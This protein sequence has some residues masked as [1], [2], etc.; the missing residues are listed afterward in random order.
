MVVYFLWLA[1]LGWKEL[2]IGKT[3]FPRCDCERDGH[4]AHDH[5]VP[6]RVY[7]ANCI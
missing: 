3:A 1:G 6:A 7:L 2:E 5:P 4:A